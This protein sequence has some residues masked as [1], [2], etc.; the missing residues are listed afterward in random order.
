MAYK[1]LIGGEWRGSDDVLEV[2]FPYDGSLVGAV[3]MASAADMDDAMAAAVAGFEQTR[4]LPSYRRSEILE[5][6]GRLLRQRFDEVVEAM[7]L[8]GGKNHK[9]AVGEATRALETLKVSAEEARRIGGEVFSIDWTAAGVNRQGFTRRTPIGAVLGITPFNYPVNLACHKIGPA[10]AAGNSIIIKPA[11]KT[12]LSSV[13]LAEI[14]LEAGYPPPAFSMLNAWGPDAEM[15]AL[16]RRV[17]M[18]SFTGSSAVGWMLKSKA[19]QKKVTL[20]LGGNAGVIVH[21]DADLADAAA[22]SAA[23]GFANAG[24]NCISVQRLLIQRDV[25]EDFADL[26]VD[27]VKALKVGDPRDPEVDIGPMISER[28]A[29]RAEAWVLE[30]QKAG[31]SVLYGGERAGTM[32]PPTV[33]TETAPEM[34]VNCEEVFAPV[35]TL[36][37]YDKWDEAVATIND[38]PYGLQAGVFTND[39]KRVMD[40]WER[41]EVGGVQVNGVSTFRVDHM[42]YGGIKASGYGREGIKYAIEDMTDL[43]LMVVNVG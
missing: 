2:R 23:G 21:N 33:M 32:F 15:M 4:T 37:A 42:P 38:T 11:E 7:I 12:P 31:A 22:Q 3:S 17:A 13:I 28:D 10:I 26:F 40:A 43:R 35:V 30:A 6:M 20:E 29:E 18:I 27:E 14:V 25:F 8:E 1:N 5:N 34:R 36:S 16:D 9:T 39:V 41:I 24:Q 19:G